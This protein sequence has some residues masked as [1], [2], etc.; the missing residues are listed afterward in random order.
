MKVR[1]KRDHTME[2]ILVQCLPEERL[3][4]ILSAS[5]CKMARSDNMFL[6]LYPKMESKS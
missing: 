3:K 5:V 1:L 4:D 6:S 2:G